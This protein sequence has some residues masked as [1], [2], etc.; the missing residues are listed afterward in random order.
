MCG[1]SGAYLLLATWVRV[2]GVEDCPSFSALRVN[3]SGIAGRPAGSPLSKSLDSGGLNSASLVSIG[4][5]R[6]GGRG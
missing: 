3:V 4:A 2:N 5:S 1:S 6:N